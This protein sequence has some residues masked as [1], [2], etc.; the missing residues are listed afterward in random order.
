MCAISFAQLRVGHVTF[1]RFL[2]LLVVLIFTTPARATDVIIKDAGTL[3]LAGTTY[4]LDGVDAPAFDQLCLNE[5]ADAYACGADAREQLA[6][7]IGDHAVRCDDLGPDKSFGRWHVGVCTV[8]GAT[9]SLNQQV[10]QKG[11]ALATA[12]SIKSGFKD[13]EAAAKQDSQGL[14]KGCFVAGTDFRHGN[15]AAAALL[16][17][18][19]RSDKEAETRAILFP[20]ETVAPPGCTIKGK[21]A[22][23]ARVTG[24]FG[25]YHL[26]ACRT[27]ETLIKPDRWFCSEEDAQADGF[28]RAFNCRPRKK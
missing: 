15:K 10:V 5:F 27:Y 17:G 25:I 24:N 7:L 14:W 16:G 6:K 11:F 26:Q 1:M 3:Q 28:R 8:E 9:S 20:S 13:D 4:R 22:V 12:S 18:S 23:R 19:C 2:F 21:L